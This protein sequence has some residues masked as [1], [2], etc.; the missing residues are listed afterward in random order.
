MASF[1][2]SSLTVHQV[3]CRSAFPGEATVGPE[4]SHIGFWPGG[5]LLKKL[6]ISFC[7]DTIQS[8]TYG[9]FDKF[10]ETECGLV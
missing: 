5:G 10:L 7:R 2:D 1:R 8:A 3:W 6:N 4:K 9:N